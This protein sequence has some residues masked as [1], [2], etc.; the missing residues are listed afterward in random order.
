MIAVVMTSAGPQANEP[1]AVCMEII[2]R[3]RNSDQIVYQTGGPAHL[4][5]L[6]D[7]ALDAGLHA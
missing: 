4:H 6:L 2:E 7:K 1:H 5:R 3:T